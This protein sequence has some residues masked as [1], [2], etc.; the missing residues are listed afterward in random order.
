MF[1]GIIEELGE[2]RSLDKKGPISKLQILAPNIAPDARAGQ[3]VCVNGACLTVVKIEKDLLCL[4]IMQETLRRTNLGLLK[5]KDRVNLERALRVDGRLDGH[6]LSGH[7]DG[8]GI[9]RKRE[10]KGGDLVIEVETALKQILRYIVLKGSVALDGV[11]LTVSILENA[12][13]GVNIIPYTIDNTTLGFKKEG[14]MVNIE[15]DIL[16]KYMDRIISRNNQTSA[17]NVTLS[18][19][20]KHGFTP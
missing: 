20:R 11:S 17:S 10:I 6:F 8:T 4:E 15:C 14:D 5:Q 9:I 19:L 1:S 7:I 13:F 18:L 12:I 2:V 16:A 3:S